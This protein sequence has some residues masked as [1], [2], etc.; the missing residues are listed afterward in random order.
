MKKTICDCVGIGLVF[1]E[2]FIF[3]NPQDCKSH[4]TT[5]YKNQ[6]KW[7]ISGLHELFVAFQLHPISVF[8]F[9][10]C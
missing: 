5:K 3:F 6:S 2:G 7:Y 9:T 10:M 8:Q 1:K 4:L